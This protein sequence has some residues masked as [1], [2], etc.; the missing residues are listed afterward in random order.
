MNDNKYFDVPFWQFYNP[1]FFGHDIYIEEFG[2]GICSPGW[3]FSET[4]RNYL[5]QIVFDGIAHVTVGNEKAFPVSKGYAFCLP[6]NVPHSYLADYNEPTTRAWISW[7]GEFATQIAKQLNTLSNPHCLKVNNL[8][9][10]VEQFHGL[11]NARS[12]SSE[13]TTIIYSCFY[14]ILANCMS[15]INSSAKMQTTDSLLFD[16][17]IHYVDTNI[18]NQLS[19]SDIAHLFGY[20]ASS[21]YRKFKLHTGLS[22]KE[23]IQHRR[24]ALAMGLICST[25]LSL[26]EI[27]IRCGYN[28]KAA[29]NMLFL[30][31]KNISLAQYTKEHRDS[32]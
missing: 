21:I 2:Y 31:K 20:D 15:P 18:M 11:F 5:L 23:Y 24:V 32:P 27:A 16:D 8:D 12:R 9:M 25:D 3:I 29:L 13:A 7:S 6:P 22:L 4:R 14:K 28:D 17:I 10:V 19:V 1:D 26:D 30:R